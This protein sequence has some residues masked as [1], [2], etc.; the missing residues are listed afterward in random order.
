M[1]ILTL[2]RDDLLGMNLEK[3]ASEV[4]DEIKK[5]LVERVVE[6]T[7]DDKIVISPSRSFR[8]GQ[9]TFYL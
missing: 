4:V 7:H 2:S 3:K 9:N 5:A 6:K 8:G 1:R